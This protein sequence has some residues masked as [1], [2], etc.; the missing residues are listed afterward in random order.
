[1][2]V[3]DDDEAIHLANDSPCGLNSS[4]WTTDSA[5]AEDLVARLQAGNVCVNDVMVSYAATD[6]P[7]GG[8]KESG[9]GRVHGPDG[10]RE[11][12]ITK[13]VL[14]DRFGLARETW[15]FPTPRLLGGI[16]TRFLVL[17]HRRGWRNKLRGLLP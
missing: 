3:C 4:V 14:H 1:M 6:L 13:S 2:R 17:R 16:G 10:L 9:I 12:S 8:V 15:W 11:M 7:F 5:R